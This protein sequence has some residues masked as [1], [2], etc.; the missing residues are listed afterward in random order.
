MLNACLIIQMAKLSDASQLRWHGSFEGKS[1][2]KY[3][4]VYA[5]TD[6]ETIVKNLF[7][8]PGHFQLKRLRF[9]I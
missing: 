7:S 3:Y 6:L 8:L 9:I 2:V 5:F 1:L 4:A